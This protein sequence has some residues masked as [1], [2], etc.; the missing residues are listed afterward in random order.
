MNSSAKNKLDKI[1]SDN[2]SGSTK[3]LLKL[4]KWSK[5]YAG[6][7]KT[8]LGMI[9]I[10]NSRL[11]AFSTVQSFTKEFRKIID[12]NNK[13]QILDFINKQYEEIDNRYSNLFKNSLPYLKNCKR[14]VTLSNSK[15]VIE[16]LKRLN[17][18]KKIFV[19][20][21]ESRPQL[22]GRIMAK[23]LLK[24]KI[25]VEIIPE[26]LLPNAV[27]KADVAISGADI[28]LSNG[29]IVN[30]TGSRS[31]AIL[32]KY[33]KK[34][35]YVLATSDKFSKKKKYVPEKRDSGEIWKYSH[36]YLTKTN[37][38]FEVVEKKLITKV[39]TDKNSKVKS[40]KSKIA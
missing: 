36:K 17:E 37:F 27:E 38:Y 13:T 39:I 3:V 25:K 28:I 14:I 10:T 30:K 5:D 12:K 21:A 19:T 15:T 33:F 4:I 7:K 40:R 16:I 18:K 20:V 22:E 11:K 8:L 9:D 23:E 24:N 2:K 35:F 31:L 1:L 34:P 32:C 26:A 29:N 6:D